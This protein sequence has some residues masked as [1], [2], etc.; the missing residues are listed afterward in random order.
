MLKQ[1][2]HW[3]QA[4]KDLHKVFAV[5]WSLFFDGFR[6]RRLLPSAFEKSVVV[7]ADDHFV[8]TVGDGL[9]VFLR[10]NLPNSPRSRVKHGQD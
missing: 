2:D 6:S 9:T 8:L 4:P 3:H 1:V 10:F 7:L 5:I